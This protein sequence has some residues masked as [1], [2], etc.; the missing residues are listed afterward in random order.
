MEVGTTNANILMSVAGWHHDQAVQAERES[1][2]DDMKRHGKIR[3]RVWDLSQ[4]PF[5]LEI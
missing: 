5:K 1:R 4:I 2:M 3:D